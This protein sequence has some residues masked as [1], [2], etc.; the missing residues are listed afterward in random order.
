MTLVCVAVLLLLPQA[1]A[2][3]SAVDAANAAYKALETRNY[4]AA[5]LSFRK[6]LTL[7]PANL[8]LRQDYAYTLLK[9]GET[10]L[11]RDEFEL[12]LK[13][14]PNADR[15]ALEY[16]YL[17]FE[18]RKP[19]EARRT[20]LRLSKSAADPAIRANINIERAG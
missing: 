1:Y 18:T 6:S 12:V 5:L 10:A 8:S 17:C 9:T 3:E 7:D 14:S 11:A 2:G 20:F 16:A 4:D 13:R 19:V 15:L